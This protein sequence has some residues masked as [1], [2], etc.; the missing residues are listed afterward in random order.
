[1][2]ILTS[3]LQQNLDEAF[4][5]RLHFV[6]AF[7]MPDEPARQRIWAQHL[8]DSLPRAAN[9]DASDLAGR[10]KFSGGS[11]RN[12]ALSAAFLAARDGEVLTHTHL[13]WAARREFQKLGKLVDERLFA[14]DEPGAS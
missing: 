14:P 13:L 4:L 2:V 5:R 7:P 3:N 11:I 12:V 8:P 9:V 6:V 1:V 10:W